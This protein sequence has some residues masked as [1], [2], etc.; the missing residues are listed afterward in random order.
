MIH[1]A[2]KHYIPAIVRYTA[3]LG[4][5]ICKV[6]NACP[7]AETRVQEQLLQ[8]TS[9]LLAAAS[10]ALHR[11]EADMQ[12]ANEMDCLQTLACFHHDVIT[13]DMKALRTPIDRL[14]LLVDKDL[15]PVPTY[16]D[17]MFEV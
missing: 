14:E 12:K 4:D 17:L 11:L 13:A 15:W 16:G 10:D 1:M 8:E 9:G 6:R 5:S 2:A 7:A 3:R